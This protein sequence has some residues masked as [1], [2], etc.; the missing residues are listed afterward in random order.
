MFVEPRPEYL[1]GN[2]RVLVA[3]DYLGNGAWWTDGSSW[4]ALDIRSAT[5]P[6]SDG[7]RVVVAEPQ[8]G[9]FWA[10]TAGQWTS[11]RSRWAGRARAVAPLV[12]DT[13]VATDDGV[14]QV[15]PNDEVARHWP[16]LRGVTQL[17]SCGPTA[18]W[19]C[20]RPDAHE[21][22]TVGADTSVKVIGSDRGLRFPRAVAWHGGRLWIGDT[23][24]R[25]L[26]DGDANVVV[27][28]TETLPFA[29]GVG[30]LGS[31]MWVSYPYVGEAGPANGRPRAHAADPLDFY[32]LALQPWLGSL[33]RSHP[34][35]GHLVLPEGRTPAADLLDP[36]DLA[37]FNGR[38]AVVERDR[39]SVTLFDA[40]G[41]REVVPLPLESQPRAL[42]AGDGG[43]YVAAW[44]PPRLYHLRPDG[45]LIDV[46]PLPGRAR[47]LAWTPRGLAFGGP[48][49]PSLSILSFEHLEPT[50]VTRLPEPPVSAVRHGEHLYV[51]L[52]RRG[53]ILKVGAGRAEVVAR[54]LIT[55][56]GLAVFNGALH[57]AESLAHRI[58]RLPAEVPRV[59]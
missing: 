38:L 46:G 52:D 6:G 5:A 7:T 9:R 29:V 28:L 15:G 25:C 13:L 2:D 39:P 14:L 37:E 22:V 57:V 24:N 36:V 56:R 49:D 51:G 12:A 32:P 11:R 20:S 4:A 10:N 18:R 53:E 40:H 30:F 21:V 19:A 3:N 58:T 34:A 59:D 17:A 33:C 41:G 31:V 16:R 48:D 8:A 50:E 44:T 47:V 43:L 54:D 45:R 23:E 27:D 1:A 42:A 55:P 26:R 35:T